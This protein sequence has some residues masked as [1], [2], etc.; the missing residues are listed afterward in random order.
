MTALQASLHLDA[1]RDLRGGQRQVLYLLQGLI[2]RGGRVLLCCP[3]S[4]PL[5]ARATEATI[6]CRPLTLRSGFDFPSAVRLARLV[7]EHDFD[8]VHAHDAHSHSIARAAQG[9][10]RHPA[11]LRNLFVSRRSIGTD[12]SALG[13]LK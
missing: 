13:R 9:I 3:R 12:H 8:L 5:F 6:P 1:G 2:E 11:L 7:A 4:A 10:S